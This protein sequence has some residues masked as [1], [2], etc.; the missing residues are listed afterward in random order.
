MREPISLF[1]LTLLFWPCLSY[2]QTA[3]EIIIQGY[4]PSASS[5]TTTPS[6]TPSNTV[7]KINL[8]PPPTKKPI[9]IPATQEELQQLITSVDLK[10]WAE[11][12]SYLWT[13]TPGNYRMPM[14][15]AKNEIQ[16]KFDEYR[17]KNIILTK[18]HAFRLASALAEPVSYK[19]PGLK[20]IACGLNISVSNVEQP[21]TLMCYFIILDARYLSKLAAKV[22]QNSGKE[23]I[24]PLDTL[25]A[26]NK[27]LADNCTKQ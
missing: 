6:T 4:I 2:S 3:Q 18:D 20:G 15:N 25:K 13:C 11:F 7:S 9:L 10:R 14:Y 22:A 5:I 16:A 12:G 19:A 21:Y 1:L 8:P 23:E 24:L 27:L 26:I 17:K